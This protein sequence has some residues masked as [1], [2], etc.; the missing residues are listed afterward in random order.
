MNAKLWKVPDTQFN[1]N[2]CNYLQVV[3]WWCKKKKTLMTFLRIK[4][5]TVIA[6]GMKWH[7]HG[8]MSH[9]KETH[10]V[11]VW[12][13]LGFTPFGPFCFFFRKRQTTGNHLSVMSF[14]I[15]MLIFCS[16]KMSPQPS[17]SLIGQ[18][19]CSWQ[20]FTPDGSRSYPPFS[21]SGSHHMLRTKKT[22]TL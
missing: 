9:A 10:T 22:N 2:K 19:L 16:D 15:A 18:A 6:W 12:L 5:W 13:F 4:G 17:T 11:P 8:S 3:D 7:S 21:S 1:L 14:A 20:N